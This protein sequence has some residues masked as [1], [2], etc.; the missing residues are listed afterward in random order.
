MTENERIDNMTIRE[1]AMCL[2]TITNEY[3]CVNCWVKKYC[4]ADDTAWDKCINAWTR[5]LESEVE[6]NDT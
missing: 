2:A 5:W 3:T 4:R 1:R 6:D